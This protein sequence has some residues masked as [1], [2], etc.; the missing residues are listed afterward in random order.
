[1]ILMFMNVDSYNL[2]TPMPETGQSFTVQKT[3]SELLHKTVLQAMQ[4]YYE[5]PEMFVDYETSHQLSVHM[6]E[7][8]S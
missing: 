6:T 1:M 3:F 8:P 7:F 4:V 5:T 2:R